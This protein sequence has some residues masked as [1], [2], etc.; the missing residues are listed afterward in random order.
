MFL[1][2]IRRDSASDEEDEED[3]D[4]SK[5]WIKHQDF[6]RKTFYWVNDI[7]KEVTYDEPLIPH[8]HEKDMLN[9]RIKVFWVVQDTWYDGTI[10]DYHRRKHRHRVEYDDGD[11]EWIDLDKEAERVQVMIEDG[12]WVMYNL[13]KTPAG[14][15]ETKKIENKID[16]DAFKKQAWEDATQWKIISDDHKGTIIFMSQNTGELRTGTLEAA[17][18]IIDDDGHGLPCF[19]NVN[20]QE[21]VFEDPRFIHDTDVDLNKQRAFVMQECRYATYFCKALWEQYT[22]ASEMNDS[23]GQILACLK[24]KKSNKVKH[25]NSFTIRATALYKGSSVIDQPTNVVVKQEIEYAQWLSKRMAEMV[26]MAIDFHE[27][28]QGSKKEKKKQILAKSGKQYICSYCKRETKRELQF[29]ANC[30]K[31]QTIL[32]DKPADYDESMFTMNF[33]NDNND[34]NNKTEIIEEDQFEE[35]DDEDDDDEDD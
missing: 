4:Y 9:Q 22:H 24:A 23:R 14:F 18:W 32:L 21:T 35:D 3:F 11:H 31:K 12:S 13:Y 6:K 8:V 16:R 10:T 25:L 29:C 5:N 34:K 7:T 17:E 2:S 30:G 28:T 1:Q 33:K 27:N 26:Q 15:V 20:T 19:Y